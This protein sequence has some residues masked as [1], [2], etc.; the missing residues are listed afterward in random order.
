LPSRSLRYLLCW[1]ACLALFSAPLALAETKILT[2][3][4]IIALPDTAI[5]KPVVTRGVLTYHEPGH[6]MAFIQDSTGAMY[7]HVAGNQNVVP[8]DYVEVRG[9]IDPGL[10][11]R[12]I[13]G[14]DYDTSPVIRRLA[15]GTFP[16]PTHLASLSG[17]EQ[18]SGARWT[19]AT[20]HV[21][22]V[23]LEGDRARLHLKEYPHIPVFIAGVTR[24]SMLPNHLADLTVHADGVI[25]DSPISEKPLVMQRQL[26]I[27][28]LKFVHIPQREIDVNKS[29]VQNEGY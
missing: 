5:A 25:A 28:G 3:S 6:R 27:P 20:I 15:P 19:R 14:K 18:K 4:E 16:E 23:T 24:P 8:G 29:L 17:I 26:L 13:R 21:K 12:N 11:G 9:F 22:S 2:I 10:N 1:G 7:V